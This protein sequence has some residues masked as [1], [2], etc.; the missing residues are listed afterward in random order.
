VSAFDNLGSYRTGR[1]RIRQAWLPN[2]SDPARS[3]RAWRVHPGQIDE[4]RTEKWMREPQV[5]S[6]RK[7]CRAELLRRL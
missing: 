2:D 3:H 1:Y 6:D 5:E 7:H 4:A